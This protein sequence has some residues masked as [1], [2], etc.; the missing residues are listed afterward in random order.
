MTLEA[1]PVT[2]KFAAT[3]RSFI[4]MAEGLKVALMVA[5][6]QTPAAPETGKVEFTVIGN[7]GIAAAAVVK[8]H[9]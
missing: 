5:L 6:G 7:G 9:T 2:L 3:D 8:V 1:G 4:R